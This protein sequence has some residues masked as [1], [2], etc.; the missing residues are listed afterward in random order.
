MVGKSISE[1]TYKAD[2]CFFYTFIHALR[3]FSQV[4]FVKIRRGGCVLRV[5]GTARKL[6]TMSFSHGR[7]PAYRR[8][9]LSS[10][11]QVN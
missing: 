7:Q 11:R 3:S 5:I 6:R 2:F 8:R 10:M 4:Q 9:L 1:M